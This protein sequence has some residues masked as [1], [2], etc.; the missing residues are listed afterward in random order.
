[1]GSGI[2]R[3]LKLSLCPAQGLQA[4]VRG[5]P[6]HQAGREQCLLLPQHR[7]NHDRVH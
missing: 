4:G 7:F 6:V 3:M 1:M 5:R 2:Y